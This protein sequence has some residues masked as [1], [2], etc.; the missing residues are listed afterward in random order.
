M[1]TH[2]L[3]NEDGSFTAMVASTGQPKSMLAE[4]TAI[5]QSALNDWSAAQQGDPKRGS[6]ID[7]MQWPG[8]GEV[9]E[10]RLK[11]F[12]SDNRKTIAQDEY[13]QTGVDNAMSNS[14]LGKV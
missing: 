1:S 3:P 9:L 7:L 10:R 6:V 12:A 5:E 14:D 4:L 13:H 2:F 8:W 11:E